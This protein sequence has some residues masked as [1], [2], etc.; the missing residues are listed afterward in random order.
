MGLRARREPRNNGVLDRSLLSSL[1]DA[2]YGIREGELFA[3]K[4]RIDRVLGAGGM[5]VVLL[6]NHV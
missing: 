4:Y 3:G 6:A 5:G 1:P 2:R